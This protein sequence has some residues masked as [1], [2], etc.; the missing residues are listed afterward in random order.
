MPDFGGGET[1]LFDAYIEMTHFPEA[2]LRVGKFK[3]PFG[4][5][6]LQSATSLM[7][8]ERGFPT[9][10]GP[11]RDV[12]IQLSENSER[13]FSHAVGVFN[14]VADGGSSDLIWMMESRYCPIY[15]S[16]YQQ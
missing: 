11:N 13:G 14:G 4:L 7:F 8:L 9:S 3:G 16:L 5:E 15:S 10:L 1:E 6:R 12:G 2:S